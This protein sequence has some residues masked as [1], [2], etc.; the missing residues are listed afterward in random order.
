[1]SK[2]EYAQR[3]AAAMA[4]LVLHQQDCVGLV[5]FDSEI[6]AIL[7]PSGNPSHLQD[8]LKVIEEAAPGEKRRS[9]RSSTTWPNGSS[10]G[11][12]SSS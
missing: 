7:R 4:Y 3:A 1:M 2:L 10:G 5:T 12:S 6:R 11:E 8:V 9:A